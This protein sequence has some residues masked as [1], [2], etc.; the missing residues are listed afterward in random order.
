MKEEV[1]KLVNII[2]L[3]HKRGAFDMEES[4]LIYQL[5]LGV[6]KCPAMQEPKPTPSKPDLMIVDEDTELP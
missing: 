6:Q 1:T 3:A 5:I 4:A 2:K